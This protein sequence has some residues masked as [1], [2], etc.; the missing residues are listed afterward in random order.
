MHKEKKSIKI[1]FKGYS[2]DERSSTVDEI[3]DVESDN[4]EPTVWDIILQEAWAP[5]IEQTLYDNKAY[6][7]EE[8][9]STSESCQAAYSYVPPSLI[10]NITRLYFSKIELS[11]KLRRDDVHKHIMATKRKLE[12]YDDLDE[13]ESVR[14][15][16]KKRKYLIQDVTGALSDCEL[17]T[18]YDDDDDDDDDNDDDDD[19]ID[20]DAV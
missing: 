3:S 11:K 10:R 5:D 15:A 17:D 2:S 6:F 1:P 20:G 9:M 8:G 18:D 16:I 12:N 14:Y 19:D 7:M 13:N 4:A